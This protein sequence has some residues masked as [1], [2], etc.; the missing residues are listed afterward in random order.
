MPYRPL[1]ALLGIGTLL[2]S[3]TA[4]QRD[5]APRLDSLEDEAAYIIGYDLG[6][7]LH[8][9]M[10]DA[11]TPDIFDE[12]VLV[13]AIRAG[14]RGDSA[15]FNPAQIDSIMRAFQ[16]T[17]IAMQGSRNRAESEAF[18]AGLDGDSIQ[19]TESGLRYRVIEAGT[20]A[21]AAEGDTV[22]VHYRGTLPDS[23]EFDS[24]YRRGQP[25]R[26]IVGQLIPGWNEALTMMQ[27]GATW[28]LFIPPDLA[29]GDQA[30]P[31]IGPGRALVFHVELLDVSPQQG[32]Q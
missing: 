32:G 26:F 6:S 25:A 20:G 19:V 22:T 11:G 24:S 13:A 14:F 18:L 2:V 9:Q 5:A 29:Y 1:L 21:S 28:E 15:R 23:T 7:A 17:L 12:D 27:E 8:H 30:P 3:L 16:D 31:Q 4:C 10:E